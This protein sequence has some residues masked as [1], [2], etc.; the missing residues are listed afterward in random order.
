MRRVRAQQAVP[1]QVAT[2]EGPELATA[3]GHG[4]DQLQEGVQGL[5]GRTAAGG[6]NRE[7]V[8]D[9]ASL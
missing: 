6:P 1:P 3:E 7:E 8:G 4:A 2:A 9:Q 5:A